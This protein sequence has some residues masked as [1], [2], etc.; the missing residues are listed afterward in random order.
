MILF[1]FHINADMM[2]NYIQKKA[3]WYRFRAVRCRY[4]T[5]FGAFAED[6]CNVNSADD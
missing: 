2:Q 1:I 5:F 6:F 3:C 4:K